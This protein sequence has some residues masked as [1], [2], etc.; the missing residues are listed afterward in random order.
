M[1]LPRFKWSN[2]RLGNVSLE[3]NDIINSVI[4]AC[5]YDVEFVYRNGY[6]FIERTTYFLEFFIQ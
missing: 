4:T 1:E 3:S 2:Q 5:H 6:Y